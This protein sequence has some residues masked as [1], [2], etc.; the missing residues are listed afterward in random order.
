MNTLVSFFFSRGLFSL[1]VR[2]PTGYQWLL[3]SW[4]PDDSPVREK[5]LYA[6]TKATF[7][8]LFGS[9]TEEYF[10]TRKVQ[11]EKNH[12]F[13]VPYRKFVLLHLFRSC[14]YFTK[15]TSGQK[16]KKKKKGKKSVY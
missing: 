7:K 15:W 2:S 8:K 1:D 3:I 13:S 11:R 5:M 12:F 16:R 4:S 6:S 9:I 14:Q 10:A